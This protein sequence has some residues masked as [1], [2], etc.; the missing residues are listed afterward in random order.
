MGLGQRLSSMPCSE[1]F[2]MAGQLVQRPSLYGPRAKTVAEPFG[3]CVAGVANQMNR[4]VGS[5]SSP[6]NGQSRTLPGF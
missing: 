1:Q 2:Q 4:D 6:S 3:I 5:A